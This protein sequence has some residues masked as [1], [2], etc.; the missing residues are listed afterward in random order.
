MRNLLELNNKAF[1]FNQGDNLFEANKTNLY[2][3]IAH[4]K[5]KLWKK[6][7]EQDNKRSTKFKE[8]V[9]EEKKLK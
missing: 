9:D 3:T 4:S 7:P 5:K 6:L 8:A 2:P 1:L